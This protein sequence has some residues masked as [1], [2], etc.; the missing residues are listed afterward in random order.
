MR[1]AGPGCLPHVLSRSGACPPKCIACLQMQCLWRSSGAS[2]SDVFTATDVEQ[3][4]AL[5]HLRHTLV[6]FS[7]RA[8]VQHIVRDSF[9]RPRPTRIA[10]AHI[11]LQ[12]SSYSANS[13][14]G[15]IKNK[16]SKPCDD[17]LGGWFLSLG[18]WRWQPPPLPWPG[19][20]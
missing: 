13:M 10:S 17:P 9:R 6:R 20:R 3:A 12:F 8:S 4:K 1:V 2:L 5:M 19:D 7:P 14:L 18:W 16:N 11:S 15:C